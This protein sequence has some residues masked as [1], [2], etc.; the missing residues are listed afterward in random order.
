MVIPKCVRL[1]KLQLQNTLNVIIEIVIYKKV[2]KSTSLQLPMMIYISF[3]KSVMPK[4]PLTIKNEYD[5]I[6]IPKTV[7]FMVTLLLW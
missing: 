3:A 4:V 2:K 1:K 7:I 6:K 5:I